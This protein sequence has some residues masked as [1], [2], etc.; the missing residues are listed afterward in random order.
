VHYVNH[1]AH[2]F[3]CLLDGAGEKRDR[4]HSQTTRIYF[5]PAAAP[6]ELS[7]WEIISHSNEYCVRAPLPPQLQAARAHIMQKLFSP[8]LLKLSQLYFKS[9]FLLIWLDYF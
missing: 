1:N 4:T 9:P 8:S 2:F 7:P 3:I 6:K 5:S